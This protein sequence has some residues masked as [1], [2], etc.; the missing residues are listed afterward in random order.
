M[1]RSRVERKES[2]TKLA[3]KSK[4]Q[5]KEG[6]KG[7]KIRKQ[8]WGER[9]NVKN[10]MEHCNRKKHCSN[11]NEWMKEWMKGGR[12]ELRKNGRRNEAGQKGRKEKRS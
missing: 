4:R 6:K 12:K 11:W 8:K 5:S 9:T 7:K 2:K 3:C 1:K 10:K